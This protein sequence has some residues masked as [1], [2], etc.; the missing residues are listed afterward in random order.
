MDSN[1]KCILVVDDSPDD[2]HFVMEGL[3]EDYAFL[4]ATRG[5]KALQIMAKGTQIDLILMDVEMPAMN[6]YET[7]RR[8]KTDFTSAE[9]A[10]SL[11]GTGLDGN[12]GFHMD[13][14]I[15]TSSKFNICFCSSV[16][17]LF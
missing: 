3:S 4:A 1:K 16:G 14:Y 17:V 7:C 2:I 13:G 5:E 9:T 11:A 8:V 15:L 12:F 10:K 6:G